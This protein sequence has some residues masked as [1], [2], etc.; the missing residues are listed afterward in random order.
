MLVDDMAALE[1]RNQNPADATS[2]LRVCAQI[3]Y[4]DCDDLILRAITNCAPFVEA[5]FV[6]FSEKP[7]SKYNSSA[8]L[9]YRNP[10]RLEV[11][12]SSPYF[13]KLVVVQ[14]EWHSEEDQRNQCIDLA[15][16][17]GFDVMVIQDADEFYTPAAYATNLQEIAKR[18][19]FDYYRNQWICFWKTPKLALVNRYP[20]H[21]GNM[22]YAPSY[23]R[24]LLGFNACF[25]L[26]LRRQVRFRDRRMVSG[27]WFMVSGICHHLS[28]VLSDEQLLRKLGTW[29]HSAQVDAAR[30]YRTKWKSW[31]SGCRNL[32]PIGRIEWV[33]AVPYDGELPRE[34]ADFE[35]VGQEYEPTVLSERIYS[36]FL[37]ARAWLLFILRDIYYVARRA[38]GCIRRRSKD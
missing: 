21:Y 37:D 17:L 24:T 36:A 12:N 20:I 16:K 38:A 32:H 8:R 34:I 33:E 27:M 15:R 14:G 7:W 31:R 2:R 18:P 23:R 19:G 3:L 9:N 5:I 4:F 11:L 13:E 25:A 10:S 35:P 22:M 6:A 1:Q 30:W 28:Y 29:G 26:N